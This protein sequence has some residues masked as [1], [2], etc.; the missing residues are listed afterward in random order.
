MN[1]VGKIFVVLIFVMSLV[2]MA[3]AMAVY[4]SQRNWRDEVM[5][6]T[7]DGPNKPEGLRR[8]LERANHDNGELKSAKES[9]EKQY[10]SEKANLVQQLSKLQTELDLAKKER[11]SLEAGRAELDKKNRDAVAAMN[12]T[13]ANSSDYSEQLKKVRKDLLD[14]QQDRDKM[15]KDVV[16]LTDELNQTVND[17]E[18]LRK[19]SVDLG[20]DLAKAEEALR[21]HGI[22]KNADFKSKQPPKI[23]ARV[24]SVNGDSLIEISLGSDAGLKKG[25][26]LQ[27]SRTSGNHPVYVGRVEVVRTD[28][29]RSVCKIDPNFQSSN[30]MVDDRV[31]SEPE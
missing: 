7:A 2:F 30:V 21:W 4:A 26:L 5:R 16:R 1:L 9:L 20:R 8:Q 13:Q 31:T 14:S 17:K 15:F 29:G 3:L 18:Q 28:P 22:N 12:A 24:V 25:H 10:S 23:E 6:E 19:R 11:K 27:I